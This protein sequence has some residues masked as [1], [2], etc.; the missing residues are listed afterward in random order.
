MPTP[1]VRS[2]SRCPCSTR[3]PSPLMSV[4]SFSCCC[5]NISYFFCFLFSTFCFGIY[6][7][8][9]VQQARPR[10]LSVHNPGFAIG[11]GLRCFACMESWCS[12]WIRQSRV[13]AMP[14][15][16]LSAV[17]VVM[18]TSWWPPAVLLCCCCCCGRPFPLIDQETVVR[19]SA[20][21]VTL[22]L[23][24]SNTMWLVLGR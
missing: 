18:G 15:P 1:S 3:I 14:I 8:F 12:T 16:A 4:Y 17:V 13:T 21:H 5:S 11:P 10:G 23:H 19:W 7:R 20:R 2:V 24:Y 9:G 22:E 6:I